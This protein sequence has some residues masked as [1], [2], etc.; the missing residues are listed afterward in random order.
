MGHPSAGGRTATR[1]A[2][3]SS[4]RHARQILIGTQK[5]V[6]WANPEVVRKLS[7]L[8]FD[9]GEPIGPLVASIQTDL[10]DLK[11]IRNAAAHLDSTTGRA[12]DGVATRKLAR[13]S[14]SITVSDFLLS[15]DPT[16]GGSSTILDFYVS[17]L[18]A[19]SHNVVSWT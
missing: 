16:G 15:M 4:D 5:Y 11:T 12:L 13:I 2:S 1:F 8:Y 6:D 9:N 17:L 18:D 3:P 19:A 10:F 7:K 14:Q